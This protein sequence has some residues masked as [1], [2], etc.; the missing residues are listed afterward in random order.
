M[1]H[2]H[3]KFPLCLVDFGISRV[4]IDPQTKQPFPPVG[5]R[6][7]GTTKYASIN[8]FHHRELGP[9]DDLSSWVYML[10]ELAAGK[11]PWAG[12]KDKNEILQMKE[13]LPI[14]EVHKGKLPT[15]F[16]PIVE[17]IASWGYD[18]V[19]NYSK[20]A[21]LLKQGK[22]RE[23]LWCHGNEWQWLWDL[24]RE[25]TEHVPRIPGDD[26]YDTFDPAAD[27]WTEPERGGCCSIA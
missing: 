12:I 15:V 8:A 25:A 16:S 18:D 9:A 22:E 20:I 6:F 21:Q 11:L 17:L 26:Q 5:G 14:A 24:D 10:C 19:P 4:H 3:A 23:S 1:L 7:V 27:K 13:T 2:P